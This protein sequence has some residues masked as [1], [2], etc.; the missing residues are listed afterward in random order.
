MV[1]MDSSL[2]PRVKKLAH[3][4]QL[5]FASI[6]SSSHQG[7]PVVRMEVP[8]M[9][10]TRHRNDADIESEC[11]SIEFRRYVQPPVGS[12]RATAISDSSDGFPSILCH[13]IAQEESPF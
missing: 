11:V 8:R 12:G 10:H 7:Q 2:H 3:A 6:A 13:A 9:V 4:S 1:R 5:I